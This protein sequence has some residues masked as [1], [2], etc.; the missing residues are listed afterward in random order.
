VVEVVVVMGFRVSISLTLGSWVKNSSE[1]SSRE[2]FNDGANMI[3]VDEASPVLRHE[4]WGSK[5]EV[6]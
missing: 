4:S 1:S 2:R 5:E 3:D 6:E